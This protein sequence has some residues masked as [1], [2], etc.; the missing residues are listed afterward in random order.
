MAGRTRKNKT[1]KG[2]KLKRSTK[3]VLDEALEHWQHLPP[4]VKGRRSS[5]L[6]IGVIT[7]AKEMAD[8]IREDGIHTNTCTYNVLNEICSNC[9]CER[10]PV[11][12]SE[13]HTSIPD[14]P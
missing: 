5:E 1:R 4:H 14:K 12:V 2:T 7:M 8:W 6:F 13:K 10:K 3:D 11:P 9:E